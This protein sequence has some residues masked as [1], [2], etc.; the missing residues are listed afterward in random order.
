MSSLSDDY[1][2]KTASRTAPCPQ[3]VNGLVFIPFL[4]KYTAMVVFDKKGKLG[5]REIQDSAT[6][7]SQALVTYH[8]NI[9]LQ[10]RLLMPIVVGE[11]Q[12]VFPDSQKNELNDIINCERR[13]AQVMRVVSVLV[14]RPMRHC[15]VGMICC[16]WQMY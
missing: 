7:V 5:W 4:V 9:F 1:F 2:T 14:D 16:N 12:I 10:E 11:R 15:L 8:N 3:G 13:S 6:L